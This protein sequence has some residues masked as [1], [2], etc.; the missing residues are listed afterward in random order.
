MAIKSK[1]IIF[2]TQSIATAGG[3][4][5]LTWDSPYYT[6]FTGTLNQTV[7]LPNATL[8]N[9]GALKFGIENSG[10]GVITVQ[11]NGGAT[12]WTIAAGTDLYL[13]LTDNSTSAGV[14]EKDYVAIKAL[15]GKAATFNNIVTITAVDN[16]SLNF[17]SGGMQTNNG[18]VYQASKI[19]LNS[20]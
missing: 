10:T 2:A 3:T 7:V 18:R 1:D 14:W 8:M 5:T 11:T 17:G 19:G 16:S 13:T 6:I 12:L 20:Y 15:T 9:T 4:T